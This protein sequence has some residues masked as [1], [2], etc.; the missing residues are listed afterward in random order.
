[1]QR[2]TLLVTV[3]ALGLMVPAVTADKDHPDY[4]AATPQEADDE[5]DEIGLADEE[6]EDLWE[7]E[8][9]RGD[10]ADAGTE[11]QSESQN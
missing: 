11:L 5:A 10:T 9:D 4:R 2:F 8:P 6:T 7:G 3:L 1:M